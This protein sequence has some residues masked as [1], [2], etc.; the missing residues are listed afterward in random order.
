MGSARMTGIDK[1]KYDV[2]VLIALNYGAIPVTPKSRLP[3]EEV[4]E[5][6]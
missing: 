6:V 4:V 2:A 5:F 3:F 1:T